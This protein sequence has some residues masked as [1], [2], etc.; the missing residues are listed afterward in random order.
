MFNIIT[1]EQQL[2]EKLVNY[3]CKVKE[4]EQVLI[5][6]S[7]CPNTFIESLIEE[8]TKVKGIPILYRLDKKLKR[9]L[10]L[11]SNEL[12]FKTYH[13]IVKPIMGNADAVIMISGG[14]NDFELSDISHDTMQLYSKLYTK[15]IHFEIRCNK[16]WVLLKY[17]SPSFA[18]SSHLSTEK[19]IEFFF[20]VCSLDYS[21]LNEKM[22]PLQKLMEKTDKVQ[23]ITPT[24]DLTFSIKNMP[25]IKCSGECNIPDGEIYSAP[26]KNSVN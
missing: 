8:I 4:N 10:L 5:T 21:L 7:D 19:F 1:A 16:K 23:I 11:H 15:P 9:K 22:T 25:V 13:D 24:T 12:S 18:Q 20:K 6:Y 26:I 2:A 17:P 14:D 3:S